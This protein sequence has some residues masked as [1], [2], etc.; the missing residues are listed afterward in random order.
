MRVYLYKSEKIASIFTG[1]G[2][3]Q[4]NMSDVTTTKYGNFA[5][6]LCC[7]YCCSYI[8]VHYLQFYLKVLSALFIYKYMLLENKCDFTHRN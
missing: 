7:N 2:F 5:S 1:T 6:V 3:L 8:I 4:R